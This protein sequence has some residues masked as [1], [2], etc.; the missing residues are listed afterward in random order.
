MFLGPIGPTAIRGS[1]L[2]A[3]WGFGS[4]DLGFGEK[5]VGDIVC[6]RKTCLVRV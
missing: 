3:V 1:G 2:R 4:R 5:A 6:M